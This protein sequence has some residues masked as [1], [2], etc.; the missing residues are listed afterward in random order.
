MNNKSRFPFLT[1]GVLVLGLSAPVALLAQNRQDQVAPDAAGPAAQS[2]DVYRPA[3]QF[4]H[5]AVAAGHPLASTAGLRILLQGGNAADASVATLSTLHVVRPQSSGTGGNE[6]F[7]IYDKAT[8]RIYSL[9]AT[10]AAPMAIDPA[11]MTR[12]SLNQGIHAGV[13]P[14]LFGGWIAVL[15]RFGTMSL[16]EVLE[17]AIDY[18]ENGHPIEESAARSMARA[19]AR[20]EQ[21][22]TSASVF[23][24]GGE[25]P[26]PGETFRMTDLASTF[27]KV[28]EAEQQAL[29]AG[30]SRSEALQAAFDRFYKGD[31]AQEMARFYQENG[32]DF[33]LEDFAAY[34]PI[35]ADPVHTT[36]RGY[37][38]YSS[39]STSRGG[40]E[41][42]MQLNLVEG[43]DLKA[44]GHNSAEVLHLL[45][46]AI[47]VAKSDI[48]HYVGDPVFTDIPVADLLSKKYAAER[49]NLISQRTAMR[50]PE[51]GRR[52][53]VG[54]DCRASWTAVR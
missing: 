2:L 7:T 27:K 30:K 46:E 11:K 35:W 6:F 13:V 33:T 21:F 10:G 25:A 45:A 23:L 40:F 18:A 50:Y 47:K 39:P 9:G 12:E 26:E 29:R 4:V 42:A 51:A 17:P 54:V 3:V 20:F 14:G 41:V 34:E 31:I 22:P 43:F 8:D 32:G 19:Q 52:Q 5:G 28:V 24:P 36:F 44:L 15:G 49:R 48:Y 1:T 37:D 53:C 38:I 16:S